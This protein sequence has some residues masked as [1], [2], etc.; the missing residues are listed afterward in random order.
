VIVASVNLWCLTCSL[1]RH[2]N[3]RFSTIAPEQRDNDAAAQVRLSF[4]DKDV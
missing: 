4:A 2:E 1:L 3:Q